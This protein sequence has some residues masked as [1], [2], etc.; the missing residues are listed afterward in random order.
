MKSHLE[1][2]ARILSSAAHLL[3]ESFVTPRSFGER[4]ASLSALPWREVAG[5][6]AAVCVLY[7]LGRGVGRAS[8]SLSLMGWVTAAQVAIVLTADVLVRAFVIHFFA[9]RLSG[10]QE[11]W[12]TYLV[13]SF[14]YMAGM[15]GAA[16]I[17]IAF[18]ISEIN[19]LWHL[20]FAP[21][22]GAAVPM[23]LGL[24]TALRL[25]SV[26][27]LAAV[28]AGWLVLGVAGA[29]AGSANPRMGAP[30][31]GPLVRETEEI[32]S[33]VGRCS[34]WGECPPARRDLT[35]ALL[36]LSDALRGE[37]DA[38]PLR[39]APELKASAQFAMSCL[40]EINPTFERSRRVH[41]SARQFVRSVE[42]V[43][44]D[45]AQA[46]VSENCYDLNASVLTSLGWCAD[47][48]RAR[49]EAIALW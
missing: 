28:A 25:S 44:D 38:R 11:F 40:A 35:L 34:R 18:N 29:L 19:L 13:V 41:S 23:Y 31:F 7:S 26:R 14:P 9:S 12:R 42:L 30:F 39:L 10:K 24:R 17:R 2:G 4:V 37:H 32:A 21:V 43:A 46:R 27:A 3:H 16:G 22:L 48:A 49:N 8:V 20:S 15:L 36:D 5:T 1:D 45:L 6:T 33:C 47:F